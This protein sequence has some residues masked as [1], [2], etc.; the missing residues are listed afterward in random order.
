MR[1]A[2]LISLSVLI[3]AF[4][5]GSFF[6][7]DN[8]RTHRYDGLLVENAVKHGL[9]FALLKAVADARGRF[10]YYTMGE[11]GEVGLLQV[12]QEGVAEY[13][14]EVKK[15]PDY[16]FG[17]VC[18]NKEYP[19]HK[20]IVYSVRGVCNIC[21]MRLVPGLW[22]PKDNAEIGAWYLAKLKKEIEEATKN[23]VRDVTPLLV[24]AY[25]LTERSVR[26]AT[27]NYQNPDLP[28]RLRS[29]IKDILDKYDRYRRKAL[30]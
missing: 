25:C 13:K 26:E 30:K 15:N 17:Y 2:V 21:R 4:S 24:A 23:S 14:A 10:N 20:G 5:I 7:Y 6:T 9:P 27:N 22:H 3:V 8:W 19:P 11:N 12:P 16:E 1:L 29:S 18:I 28:P